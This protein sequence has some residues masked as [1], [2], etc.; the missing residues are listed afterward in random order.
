MAAYVI[1][2][3]P[4]GGD[5]EAMKAYRDKAFDTL[6]PFGGRP[7]VRTGDVDVREVRPDKSWTPTRLL[8]IE[9]PTVAAARGWYDSPAYQALL[10]LR[11]NA[12]G[13]DNMVIVAGVEE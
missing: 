11:L 9:F 13:P 4:P 10:P 3:V 1:F 7:I 6:I 5:L 8:I 12:R 2:D